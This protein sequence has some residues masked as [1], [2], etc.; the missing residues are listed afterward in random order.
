MALAVTTVIYALNQVV[1]QSA[2]PVGSMSQRP[3]ADAARVMIG[4][5]G[6][7]FISLGALIS[8]YGNLT[9]QMLNSPRVTFALADGGDFPAFFAA[10]HPRFRTPWISIILYAAMVWTLAAAAD[11]RWNAT[12][13]AVGRL[14]TYAA[15]CAALPAL[16][17]WQPHRPAFRMRGGVFF[18]AIGLLFCAAM[19]IPMGRNDL[20]VIVAT[21]LLALANWWWVAKRQVRG[22]RPEARV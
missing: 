16:R 18:A 3:L 22:P 5:G 10:I 6:A 12:L 19:I 20:L 11:F 21:V 4:G 14:F 15:V 2:L 9:S 17:R 13:S 7:V 8:V 1:A